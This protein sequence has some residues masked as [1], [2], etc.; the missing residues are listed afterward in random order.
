MRRHIKRTLSLLLCSVLLCG[1]LCVP[2]MAEGETESRRPSKGKQVLYN[3][4]DGLL[5]GFLRGIAAL[6]PMKPP[7]AYDTSPD[8]YPGMEVFLDEPAEGARWRL[9][10]A[11]ASVIPDGWFDP[12]TKLYTGPDGVFVGGSPKGED[13]LRPIIDDK[14]PK[15]LIDDMCVRVTALD[16][17]SG[18]KGHRGRG[19]GSVVFA[20]IDTYAITSYDIRIIRARLREFARQNNVV[21]INIGMLHQHSS[22]DTFGWNGPLLKSLFL[23]PFINL[24]PRAKKKP[25]TGK[26]PAFMEHLT[27]V[28]AQTI[29]EAVAAMEPGTLYYGSASAEDWIHD[30]RD[31]VVLD[32]EMH[33]LRF[34]PDDESSRETWVLNLGVHFVGLDGD[35]QRISGDSAYYAE[36]QVNEAYNANF[37]MIVSGQMAVHKRHG[38][39]ETPG[40]ELSLMEKMTGYGRAL[41]DYIAGIDNEREVEPLLNIQLREV[42]IP[43]DNPIHQLLLRSGAAQSTVVKRRKIGPALNLITETGYMELGSELAVGFGPGEIDPILYLGGASPAAEAYTG[44]DF[45]FTPMKDMVRG[46]RK[47][48]MFSLMNDRSFYY[49]APNDVQNFIRFGNEEIN[50][51]SKQAAPRLLEAFEGLTDSVK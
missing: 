47:F 27:Q 6:M 29:E 35:T 16:D 46:N 8:F 10:Y 11:R 39:I 22:I 45:D 33:R 40:V 4:G 50:C 49:I 30:R 17:G 20:E 1:A 24:F 3:I 5:I 7:K 23:N 2:A 28:V 37:Q 31:P 19:R 41:A 51:L 42:R 13:P 32:E 38:P 15:E 12:E 48:L 21:S 9:G 26:N 34:V 14:V 43:V 44:E 18:P 25:Y 36:Q